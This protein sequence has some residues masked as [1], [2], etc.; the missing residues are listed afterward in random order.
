MFDFCGAQCRAT[1]VGWSNFASVCKHQPSPEPQTANGAGIAA[2]P[3]LTGRPSSVPHADLPTC[4]GHPACLADAVSAASGPVRWVLGS[5]WLTLRS[6]P[7]PSHS[8]LA[9]PQSLS[10]IVAP[11]RAQY[12]STGFFPSPRS[13]ESDQTMALLSLHLRFAIRIPGGEFCTA[14]FPILL[15]ASPSY[16][17]FASSL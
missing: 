4:A 8:R 13:C 5:I 3:V 14:G 6:V 15:R 17:Q 12:R 11:V 7:R 2:S 10:W 1:Q 16:L 9:V